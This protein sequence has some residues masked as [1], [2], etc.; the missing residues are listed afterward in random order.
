MSNEKISIV[1]VLVVW[2]WLGLAAEAERKL[3]CTLKSS[4]WIWPRGVFP[5]PPSSAAAAAHEPRVELIGSK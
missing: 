5:H 3:T 4:F 1:V 2:L